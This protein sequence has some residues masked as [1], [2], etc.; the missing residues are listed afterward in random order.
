MQFE[1]GDIVHNKATQEEGRILRI[2]DLPG[3]GL[4]Y[5][6]SVTPNSIWGTEAKEAIWKRSEVS[7]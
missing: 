3:Y 6:V 5:I 2:A 7:K 1:V 4:C